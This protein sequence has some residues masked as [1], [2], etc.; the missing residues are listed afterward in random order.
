MTKLS[1]K[2]H[3]ADI[4]REEFAFLDEIRHKLSNPSLS[5]NDLREA[6][7]A[8]IAEHENLL[9][10]I[11]KITGVGDK[12]QRKLLNAYT[13][14]NEQQEELAHK[15]E[16]LEQEIIERTALEKQLQR[17]NR[18]LSLLNRIGRLFS[19]TLDLDE[20]LSS[21][22]TELQRVFQACSASVWLLEADSGELV[23]KEIIGQEREY[24]I[25]MR[26]PIGQ[27]ITG[28]VA[29]HG[30][31]VSCGDILADPRHFDLGHDRAHVPRSMLS[32]PLQSKGRVIGVLN[33]VDPEVDHFSENDLRFA[34]SFAASAANA[35]ENAHLYTSLQ[36]S[37]QLIRKIFGRYLSEE[38]V[39]TI[40]ETP[41]GL[42]LGGEHQIVTIL[43]ADI[44]GFTAICERLSAEHVVA[45]LNQY[46]DV[47]TEIIFKYRGTIDDFLGDG[48]LAMFGAPIQRDDDVQRA[49]ACALEMQL[50]M[51]EVNRRNVEADFPQFG[52]G[53]GIHTGDVVVGNLG[54]RKRTKYGLVGQNVNLTAR[55]ESYTVGGQIFISEETLET[56]GDIL[57]IDNSLEVAPK[58]VTE[59]ITI[60]EV[61]GLGG[62]FNLYLPEKQ[63]C[64]WVPLADPLAIRFLVL[65]GKHAEDQFYAGHIITLNKTQ[66]EI[67][68]ERACR[69]LTNL[70]ISLFDQKNHCITEN[71]YAKVTEVSKR[72]T[73]KLT[74]P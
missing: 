27:G 29:Q 48:M 50:A 20:V 59:T 37:H 36:H 26:L 69:Q 71:M 72:S 38:I 52:I 5:N 42:K 51:V 28:W 40:L 67:E 30:E 19:S 56:C 16:Q 10:K 53:I 68:A 49:V 31:S 43:M 63:P 73:A 34:E 22:L 57:R 55:I 8:L 46:F 41:D 70:K 66:A 25:G 61:G 74:Q 14:I 13:R 7:R 1:D 65:Q 6:H 62:A 17:S 35:I 11:V 44:R 15:N 23:C 58:G 9:R 12:A 60:Y 45:M 21:T 54:S 24:F 39:Q 33:A 2:M 3:S 64:E 47:M 18:Q 4:Y 32:V